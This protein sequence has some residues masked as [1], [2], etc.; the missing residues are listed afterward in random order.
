MPPRAAGIAAIIAVATITLGGCAQP[1]SADASATDRG[2][3]SKG[4]AAAHQAAADRFAVALQDAVLTGHFAEEPRGDLDRDA[5]VSRRVYAQIG[6][7]TA[8]PP[9]VTFDVG[10]LYAGKAAYAAAAQ[11]G[12]PALDNPVWSRNRYRHDQRAAV[13]P[14]ASVVLQVTGGGQA[15]DVAYGGQ[16]GMAS[17]TPVPFAEFARRFATD[18]ERYGSS[19]GYILTW[20]GETVS[21]IVQVYFP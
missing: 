1:P 14:E 21:R 2:P 6:A 18:P 5:G 7:V 12:R 17:L 19:A 9:A 10:Q 4:S 20:D 11:D 3:R 8:D 16:G 13:A 15:G